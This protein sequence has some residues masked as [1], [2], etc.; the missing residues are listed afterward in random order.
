MFFTNNYKNDRINGVHKEDR[1]NYKL[2]KNFYEKSISQ[3]TILD[4]V[5]RRVHRKDSQKLNSKT[6]KNSFL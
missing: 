5:S 1:R 6:K 2:K 4:I 3:K